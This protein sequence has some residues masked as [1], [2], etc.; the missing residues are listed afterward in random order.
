[1]VPILHAAAHGLFEVREALLS[2]ASVFER[3]PQIGAGETSRI[4]GN[5]DAGREDGVDESGGVT[6]KQEAIPGELAHR[7][8]VVSLLGERPYHGRSVETRGEIVAT[9]HT[10][11]KEIS[12]GL[13]GPQEVS[14]LG[15][16]A[17]AGDVASDRDLPNPGVYNW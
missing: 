13:S 10:P 7:V 1:L 6:E 17:D 16:D 3:T 5:A 9:L 12:A 11:P 15:D 8:A 14:F 2:K 4:Q